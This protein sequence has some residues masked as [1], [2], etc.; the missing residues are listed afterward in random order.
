MKSPVREANLG[1]G[2]VMGLTGRTWQAA[3]KRTVLLWSPVTTAGFYRNRSPGQRKSI[4]ADRHIDLHIPP[5]TSASASR[6]GPFLLHPRATK[7]RANANEDER[8]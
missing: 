7:R 2:E 4:R 6:L 3:P 5:E 8:S 1:R